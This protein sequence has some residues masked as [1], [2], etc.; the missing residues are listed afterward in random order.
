MLTDE[1]L[2]FLLSQGRK[3]TKLTIV[4]CP[5]VTSLGMSR[6]LEASKTLEELVWIAVD[7]VV[8]PP[9]P[10]SAERTGV[11][12]H[13]Q[14]LHKISFIGPG[15]SKEIIRYTM[16][17]LKA[18]THIHVTHVILDEEDIVHWVRKYNHRLV[19]VTISKGINMLNNS[20]E[21][22]FSNC[23]PSKLRVLRLHSDTTASLTHA[24]TEHLLESS[25]LYNDQLKKMSDTLTQLLTKFGPHLFHLQ[26]SGIL[27]VHDKIV[28]LLCNTCPLL[29]SLHLHDNPSLTEQSLFALC[30][31]YSKSKMKKVTL[32]KSNHFS[33]TAIATAQTILRG[34][35]DWL[36]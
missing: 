20:L 22:I 36:L 18:I 10:S 33:D 16:K 34:K 2:F 4:H 8:G 27:G 13:N 29:K 30:A 25:P 28:D 7:C 1:M 31:A 21:A 6:A 15:F 3:L 24:Q 12:D 32:S 14:K 19:G 26:L 35:V 9:P 5:F 17:C 11:E 23:S